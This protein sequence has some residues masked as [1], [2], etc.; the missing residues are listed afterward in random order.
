LCIGTPPPPPANDTCAGAIVAP[1]NPDLLCGQTVPGTIAWAT[2]SS[3]ATTCGG[4]K[5]DD[6]WYTFTATNVMHTI[7]LRDVAGSTTDLFHVVYSG[8]NCG[9]LTQLYCSDPN[10]S[11]ATGLVVGQTYYI[12]IYSW[13]A[14]AGQT[15]TFNVCIGTP[16]PPPV[17][18]QCA[19]AI[20]VPVNPTH[21]CAQTVPGTIAWATAS[22]E[23]GTACAGTED[24]DVWFEFVATNPI[25][26]ISFI[27][28]AGSTTD[29]NHTLYTGNQCGTMTQVYCN[30]NN[31]STAT[32]LTVGQ[33]YKIR[34]FTATATMGQTTTFDVCVGTPPPP[35]ANDNCANAISVPVNP[36]MDCVQTVDGILYSATASPEANTCGGTDDDDVWFEF[37]ATNTAHIISLLNITGST[38]DLFH[39]VYAGNQ[40]GSLTQLLCS[41][42]N[43]SI[44]QGLTVGQTYKVRVYSWT[45]TAGQTSEFDICVSTPPTPGTNDNCA[46]AIVVPVNQNSTCALTA[47]GTIFGATASAEPNTCG[48]NDD[49]DV[50]FEFVATHTTHLISLTNIQ[51][52]TTD[53]FHVLYSG[54]QCGTMTQL[55]CSDP[56]GSVATGLIIG[57]TYKI[58]VYSWTATAPQTTTFDVCVRI[59]NTPI[60]VS[61]TQYT[62]PQLVTDVLIDSDCALV[63][64]ITWSTGSNFGQ[65]NGIGYFDAASSDFPFQNGVILATS[66][67]QE[68]VGGAA[69]GAAGWPGDTQ[70]NAIVTANEPSQTAGLQN[71]SIIEFDFIPLTNQFT[72]DFLFASD[73]YGTFQ[74]GF[75]DAFAFILTGPLPGTTWQNLAVI[76][77]TNIPVA[78]T[79][80]RNNAFNASCGS[81]NVSY[82]GQFNQDDPQ[83]AAIFYNGQTV[84]MQASA[85]VIAGQQYHI[86]LVIADYSDTAFNSA[87][88]L[89]GG[90]FDIGDIDLGGDLVLTE[91]TAL[92]D[93]ETITLDTELDPNSFTFVWTKDTAVIPGATGPSLTVTEPGVYNVVASFPNIACSYEGEVTIEF[94]PNIEEITGDPLD[95]TYC[96]PSGFH[97][98]DLTSNADIILAPLPN[99]DIYTVDFYLTEADALADDNPITNFTAFTNTVPNLQTIYTRILNQQ[100]GCIA[101]KTFDLIIQDLTPQFDITD[102]LILC[103]TSTGSITVTPINFDPT[104]P[105][106]TFVWTYGTTTLPDTDESI[107][108]AGDG[109]YTVTISNTECTATASVNVTSNPTPVAAI[110]Y[111]G[112]PF[113]SNELTGAV[114]QTGDA[115]GVYSS[116]AGLIINPA[117]GEINIAASETGTFTVTYTI[118]ATPSCPELIVTTQVIIFEA[119]GAAIV[120]SGSPYCADAG[121]A[122]VT[123]TGTTGGVYSSPIGLVIDPATGEIDLDASTAGTYTVTYSIAPTADCNGSTVS[124]QIII[125]QLPVATIAYNGTPYCSNGGTATVTQTGNTGGTYSSADGLSINAATGEINLGASVAGNYT[126]TYTIEAANGCQAVTTTADVTVT[127][128]PEAVFSYDSA[129]FCQ[130]ASIATPTYDGAAGPGTFEVVPAT[131]LSINPATGVIDPATSDEGTYTVTNKIAAANGCPEVTHSVTVTIN[132]APIGTFSYGSVA[133]CQDEETNPSPILA[134]EAGTFSA[135]PAG[136]SIDPATGIIDLANSAAGSYTVINAIAATPECAAVNFETTVVISATPVFTIVG[137]CENNV[138]SLTVIPA[139]GTFDASEASYSWSGPSGLVDSGVGVFSIVPAVEGTYTVTVSTASSCVDAQSFPVDSTSCFIQRGISP[140]DSDKNNEFDL[141]ALNVKHLSIFNRYGQEVYSRSNYTK[142]WVGQDKKGN[143]LPTGTYFYSIERENGETKT[144]WVYINRQN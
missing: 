136:L 46:D 15:T 66:S 25:H 55:Y 122:T 128:L 71:A 61:E 43:S 90:S 19:D 115:G 127:A 2:G 6:V 109:T 98:F 72:F 81:A 53:L 117:T 13:T 73:E 93:E 51:G 102:D 56:N 33:T 48:G 105:D 10:N 95:L 125:T 143:E 34:V 94:Y 92:C 96:D 119:P 139:A 41:D 62:V 22:T 8:N 100:G 47:S 132:P 57:N 3:E 40:C 106:V 83:A 49:D 20:P 113:C 137:G 78:V 121:T 79:T 118:A 1:V 17:N 84:P 103:G 69:G 31:N 130:N 12:R 50:W 124:T 76:P 74:C 36:T 142:E 39:V 101:I 116:T 16:P 141:T 135:T 68:A 27:N 26:L 97:T 70:L 42:P 107:V 37:V 59:P 29:L 54:N 114:I 104:S 35:P 28:V 80:I 110:T 144:G 24:D 77:E 99:P 38:T 75:S 64:N 82:F 131:G 30:A 11:I 120:Y 133:Y 111:N 138:Y 7:D 4:T 5:D 63:S 112:S 86:K 58:R 67:I 140:G 32:G 85:D 23:G 52:S 126:V 60:T 21:I 129:S 9:A 45:A 123:Q 91:G 65:A 14:T 88:F 44:I 18:D 87:V 108:T 134:G 89:G